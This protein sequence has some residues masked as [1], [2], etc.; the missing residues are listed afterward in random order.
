[1]Y[2]KQFHQPKKFCN[3]FTK[4]KFCHQFYGTMIFFHSKGEQ[5]VNRKIYK[6]LTHKM[7]SCLY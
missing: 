2:D 3:D 1:M 7:Q 5:Y 6:L 4:N